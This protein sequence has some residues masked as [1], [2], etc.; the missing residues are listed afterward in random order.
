MK[1]KSAGIV[2]LGWINAKEEY[3]ND[4]DSTAFIHLFKA[5]FQKCFG[6]PFTDA[7]SETDSRQFS[8]QIWQATG[9]TVGAKSIK[10]YSQ[11][12]ADPK[13][14]KEENP[15]IAT[16]DTLARY[17]MNAPE[18]TEII[19]K[20]KESHYP[21]WYDFKDRL[22]KNGKISS[23]EAIARPKFSWQKWVGPLFGLVMGG[24]L[25]IYMIDQKKNF[26]GNFNDS[27]QSLAEDS[28][29]SRG[30][31]I[32]DK[33]ADFWE[34]RNM[35]AGFLSLYTM[36]GDN[37]PDSN[38]APHIPNLL[39]R[40]ISS[41]CFTVEMQMAGFIPAKN[42]QQAGILV[43]ED[44]NF[45]G[46]ALRLSLAYND[47]FGGFKQ[48]PEILVQAITS[49][50]KG[51]AQ[52]EEIAHKVIFNWSNESDTTM[53]RNNLAY[54]GLRIEKNGKGIRLL[55]TAG[56]LDNAAFKEVTTRDFDF[57]P[58]WIAIFAIKGFVNDADVARVAV[59]NFKITEYPC[60]N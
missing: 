55:Y 56:P 3:M 42:W 49:L 31:I 40:K 27:F 54:S 50:G 36:R 5:A 47:F 53:I 9:L 14:G 29:R 46:K 10:N 22:I 32:K 51:D 16:L 11:W 43:L 35:Q 7:L 24:L 26:R 37:W 45:S 33:S 12:V 59:K 8:N 20:E 60:K 21:F 41:P 57:N 13:P 1:W 38:S 34:K 25:A 6:I 17:L 28:L 39:L 19:R 48:K 4:L 44:S 58:K 2:D 18:T 15:S 52:P 30:W 23:G